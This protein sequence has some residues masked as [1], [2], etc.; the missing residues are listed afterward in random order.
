VLSE[1]HFRYLVSISGKVSEAQV[2]DL[3]HTAPTE[4]GNS[5]KVY[6]YYFLLFLLFLFIYMFYW[7]LCD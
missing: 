3:F 6:H 7:I 2:F 5:A 4:A 1:P